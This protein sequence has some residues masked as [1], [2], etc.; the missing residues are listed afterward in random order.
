MID[1]NFNPTSTILISSPIGLVV[2][3]SGLDFSS[4]SAI[5]VYELTSNTRTVTSFTGFTC[6]AS[7]VAPYEYFTCT[8]NSLSTTIGGL[9]SWTSSETLRVIFKVAGL[10]TT[11]SSTV[12]YS[13]E[14]TQLYT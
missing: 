10:T 9:S 13:T 3:A 12:T 14:V 1:I 6:T 11:S 4:A 5:T 8:H 2:I 7:T